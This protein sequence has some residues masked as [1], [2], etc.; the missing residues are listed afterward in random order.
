[1]YCA[2]KYAARAISE[3]LRQENDVVRVTIIA[4]GVTESELADSISDAK[5]REEMKRYRNIAIAPATIAR[6]IAQ[7]ADVDTTGMIVRPT[8][9]AL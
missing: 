5:G 4:L 2:T 8:A 3:G 9:T 6:A 1:M 7:P